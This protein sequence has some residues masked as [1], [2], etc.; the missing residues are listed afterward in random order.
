MNRNLVF[1]PQFIVYPLPDELLEYED[2]A[3]DDMEIS[4]AERSGEW[5]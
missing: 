1:Q 2:E 4:A 3:I 5:V